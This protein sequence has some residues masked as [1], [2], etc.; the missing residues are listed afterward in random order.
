[1][2]KATVG[3]YVKAPESNKEFSVDAQKEKLETWARE[4][5]ARIYDFYID[6]TGMSTP[7]NERQEFKRLLRD[8][9]SRKVDSILSVD[10][11]RLTNNAADMDRRLNELEEK[12]VK[13]YSITDVIRG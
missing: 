6:N 12:G 7:I 11:D 4:N 10:Y 9:D 1:M 8:I 2:H 3:V 13:I 5:D